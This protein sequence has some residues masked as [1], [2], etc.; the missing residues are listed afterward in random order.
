M[1]WPPPAARAPNGAPRL[2]M[3]HSR[4]EFGEDS[5]RSVAYSGAQVVIDDSDDEEVLPGAPASQRHW[6]TF[7]KLSAY[8]GPGFLMSIAY[9]VRRL[10]P[11]PPPGKRRCGQAA[12]A[13]LLTGGCAARVALLQDPGNLESDLQAGATTACSLLWLLL[14]S[15][16]MVRRP[17]PPGRVV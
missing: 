4:S 10:F 14:L 3:S 1:P 6:F 11:P 13:D 9:V 2:V 17:A 16:V 12:A 7:K 5:R 8:L 15:T